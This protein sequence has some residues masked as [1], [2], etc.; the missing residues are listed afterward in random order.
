LDVWCGFAGG[1]RMRGEEGRILG[2]LDQGRVKVGRA[3][4]SVP[5]LLAFLA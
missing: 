1:E 3:A 5:S 2:Q 4:W